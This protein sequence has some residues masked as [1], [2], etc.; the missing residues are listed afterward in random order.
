MYRIW[1][2]AKTNI[3]FIKI[4]LFKEHSGQGSFCTLFCPYLFVVMFI[5]A[6]SHGLDLDSDL[7][8]CCDQSKY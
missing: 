1:L 2:C 4:R 7:L 5:K 8:S 3:S 6:L